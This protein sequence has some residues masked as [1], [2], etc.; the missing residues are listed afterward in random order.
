MWLPF[1]QCGVKTES[2]LTQLV[3]FGSVESTRVYIVENMVNS[4]EHD[5]L[6]LSLD[7][8]DR[9]I[10]NAWNYKAKKWTSAEP[11]IHMYIIC[12]TYVHIL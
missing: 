8:L 3:F 2:S 1:G 9:R 11:V 12:T 4:D 7:G 5:R 6:S 10:W